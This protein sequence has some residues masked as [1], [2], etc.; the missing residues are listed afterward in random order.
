M[1]LKRASWQQC[2]ECSRGVPESGDYKGTQVRNNGCLD[3]CGGNENETEVDTF[4]TYSG[5]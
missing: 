1:F 3:K 5:A 2:E 4:E